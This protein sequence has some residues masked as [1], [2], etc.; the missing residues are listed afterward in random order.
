MARSNLTSNKRA[1]G[2][3]PRAFLNQVTKAP[4]RLTIDDG[5]NP[6]YSVDINPL[7]LQV[8]SSDAFFSLATV[9]AERLLTDVNVPV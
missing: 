8:T 2:K 1:F 7:T 3:D 5:V 9:K 6:A 4:I